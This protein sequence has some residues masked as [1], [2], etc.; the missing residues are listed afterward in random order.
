VA[1]TDRQYDPHLRRQHLDIAIV[2]ELAQRSVKPVGE[3]AV[4]ASITGI[5]ADALHQECAT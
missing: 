1:A 2:V 3:G 5:S 4:R